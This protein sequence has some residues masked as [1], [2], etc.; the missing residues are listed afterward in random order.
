M[1]LRSDWDAYRREPFAIDDDDLALPDGKGE[2]VLLDAQ[3]A[4]YVSR[5]VDRAL[6]PEE[7]AE[8]ARLR[9][10]LAAA[11]APLPADHPGRRQMERLD[12]LAQM[13]LAGSW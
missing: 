11:V 8:L 2:L 13:A 6:K 3:I 1:S 12:A 10:Q 9:E 7:R 5:A 4:G